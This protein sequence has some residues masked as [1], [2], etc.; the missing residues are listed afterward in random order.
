[1]EQGSTYGLLRVS[2]TEYVYILGPYLE[3]RV[4]FSEIQGAPADLCRAYV[5]APLHR[6]GSRPTG[7]GNNSPA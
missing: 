3:T 4:A 7:S 5:I 1:V 2:C 6:H